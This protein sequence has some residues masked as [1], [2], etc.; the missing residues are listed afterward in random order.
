MLAC[1][2][3]LP[4]PDHS[5]TAH[6][7]GQLFAGGRDELQLAPAA[8]AR[9]GARLRDLARGLPPGGAGPLAPVLGAAIPALP[10]VPAARTVASP[11][12]GDPGALAISEC[13]APGGAP[14]TGFPLLAAPPPVASRA[15]DRPRSS[16]RRGRRRP[17]GRSVGVARDR[18]APVGPPPAG[19]AQ[20]ACT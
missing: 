10:G 13:A 2:R 9:G 15:P 7:L 5:R 18:R 19:S 17:P 6:P 1:G 20:S 14:G 4:P 16:H 8:G 11:A 12:R 3:H